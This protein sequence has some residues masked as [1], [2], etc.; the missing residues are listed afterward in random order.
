[1]AKGKWIAVTACSLLAALVLVGGG[2]LFSRM[3]TTQSRKE[4]ERLLEAL[5][6][7]QVG[8]TT[9]DDVARVTAS[10]QNHRSDGTMNGDTAWTFRYDNYPMSRFHLAPYTSMDALVV[11]KN[12]VL[13]KKSVTVFVASGVAATVEERNSGFG[14][15]AGDVSDLVPR[16][17]TGIAWNSAT[18]VRSINISD[19][20]SLEEA[21]RQSDWRI[22]LSC[23]D[24]LGG[25]VDAR[26]I[27]P[28]PENESLSA[29]SQGR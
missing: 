14:F 3:E 26:S 7:L 6:G 27:I 19:N 10:F 1:M 18:A 22:S 17:R 16:H 25:C 8:T 24:K 21:K 28:N 23:L 5:K 11:F 4:A 15:P 2:I 20:S 12:G 9:D 29:N 13:Q